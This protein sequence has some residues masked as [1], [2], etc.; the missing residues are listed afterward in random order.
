MLLDTTFLIDLQRELAGGR[1]R[2]AVRFLDSQ[3]GATP[4]ISLFTWMEFAE[5]YPAE[6]E[7]AC[8]LFL[9]RFSLILPDPAI[10]W[11]ASRIARK[12]RESGSI[13]GDHDL[14]IAATAIE[15]GMP[16]VTRNPKHF[17]RIPE[18]A[19]FGY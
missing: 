5:G 16:L 15:R 4:W 7:D 1:A 18:V 19:V 14:W 9:S 2:G 3:P 17:Q 10:A 12:L 8:R 6:K 11:R 13:I